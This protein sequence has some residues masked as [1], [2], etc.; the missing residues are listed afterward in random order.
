MFFLWDEL[1]SAATLAGAAERVL[2][3]LQPQDGIIGVDAHSIRS[4]INLYIK[5]EHHKE[6]R[7]R[8]LQAR[9]PKHY[10]KQL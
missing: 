7:L 3:D 2:S 4:M 1:V 8:F 6:K 5:E 9:R 10:A